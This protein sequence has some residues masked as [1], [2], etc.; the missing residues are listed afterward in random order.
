MSDLGEKTEQPTTKRLLDARERGQVARSLDLA[1]A[2]VLTG[3]LVLLIALGEPLLRTLTHITRHNLQPSVLGQGILPESVGGDLMLTIGTCAAVLVPIMVLMFFIAYISGLMQVG[4]L[5]TLKPLEPKLERLNIVQGV[6]RLFSKRS[7]VKGGLDVGKL[8]VI[9]IVVSLVIRARMDEL[10]GLSALSLG[11]G[12]A[13]SLRLVAEMAIWCLAVLFTL[14]I[15]DWLYQKWQRTE[16]LKMTRQEV[17]DERKTTDG[18]AQM[19]SRRMQMARTIAMQRLGNDVPEADVIVTNPT[20]YSV[21]LKYDSESMVA[22][23]VVA[24]GADY[25]ALRIRQ[26]ATTNG[27]PIVERP[28]LARALYAQV[29]VGQE[30]HSEHYE[31]V[32]E[33]LAFV[34]RLDRRAAS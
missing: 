8:L 22:P 17:K 21:A 30:I 34:Y 28:P 10:V 27:I 1:A 29:D 4:F 12:V 14:G 13:V 9:A 31:A 15:L 3:A 20:H 16:D 24:K 7:L 32:A 6:G 26:I 25:L 2:V 18:D 33:V 19:K 23:R 11:A 5:L